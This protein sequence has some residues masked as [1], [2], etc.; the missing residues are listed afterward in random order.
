MV[1]S[2][3]DN[4][5]N[6][7]GLVPD[8]PIEYKV[9]ASPVQTDYAPPVI[10]GTAINNTTSGKPLAIR[11]CARIIL[12]HSAAQ[13]CSLYIETEKKPVHQIQLTMT[14]VSLVRFL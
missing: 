2:Q 3:V 4:W 6:R 11:Q 1:K 10:N 12:L 7:H 14:S 9:D 8:F 5:Y 13:G